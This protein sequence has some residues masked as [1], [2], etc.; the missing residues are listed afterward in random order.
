[1]LMLFNTFFTSFIICDVDFFL[2]FVVF[3]IR[4]SIWLPV[5]CCYIRI[6]WCEL[7][8]VMDE[9]RYNGN[10]WRVQNNID[11][12]VCVRHEVWVRMQA[13]YL[14]SLHKEWIVFSS[15][16]IMTAMYHF[17]LA[18]KINR[19]LHFVKTISHNVILAHLSG[20]K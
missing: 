16:T 10:Y 7:E 5:M 4:L 19:L 1:M 3:M 14:H 18:R 12:D 15:S 9:R 11:V 8:L 20:R 17:L 2:V 13:L 6:V